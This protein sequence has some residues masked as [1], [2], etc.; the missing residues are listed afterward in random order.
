MKPASFGEVDVKPAWF[1]EVDVK[2]AWFGEVDMKHAY[3]SAI[4]FILFKDS[5]GSFD[6]PYTLCLYLACPSSPLYIRL[7]YFVHNNKQ[8]Q[9]S[10]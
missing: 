3:N 10:D 7:Q 9:L 2:S 5:G 6:V 1:G 8:I 4:I